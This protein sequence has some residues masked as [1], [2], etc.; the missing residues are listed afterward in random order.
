MS[1]EC[2]TGNRLLDTLSPR[3]RRILAPDLRPLTLN[4]GE[5]LLEPGEDVVQV[6]DGARG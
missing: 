4:R 2:E 1:K 6:A 5:V 3:D